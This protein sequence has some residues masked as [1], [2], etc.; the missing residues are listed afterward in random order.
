MRQIVAGR[1]WRGAAW[2]TGLLLAVSPAASEAQTAAKTPAKP[3][4]STTTR[5]ASAAPPWHAWAAHRC[6]ATT[7][8]TGPVGQA[9]SRSDLIRIVAEWAVD[10][11]RDV[12][13]VRNAGGPD[14]ALLTP[15]PAEPAGLFDP[16]RTISPGAAALAPFLARTA[17]G[18]AAGA[19]PGS[20][21]DEAARL[22][23]RAAALGGDAAGATAAIA[24]MPSGYGRARAVAAAAEDLATAGGAAAAERLLAQ[25]SAEAV[26]DGGRSL[27]VAIVGARV[28]AREFDAALAFI[29][30][31]P[32]AAARRVALFEIAL[33]Q[34]LAGQADA[35]RRTALQLRDMLP[36]SGPRRDGSEAEALAPD[37]GRLVIL[38][39]ALGET[40]EARAANDAAARLVDDGAIVDAIM[41]AGIAATARAL[42][43]GNRELAGRM[44]GIVVAVLRDAADGD[45]G[46]LD[47]GGVGSPTV[48]HFLEAVAMLRGPAALEAY[49]DAPGLSGSM[50]SWA[51]VVAVRLW[52]ERGDIGAALRLIAAIPEPDNRPGAAAL[53]AAIRLEAGDP[54]GVWQVL[55]AQAEEPWRSR[56]LREVAHAQAR[57][58]R[59]A[60]VTTLLAALP[61]PLARDT[62]RA[63]VAEALRE[64][65]DWSA[66]VAVARAIETRSARRQALKA[67]VDV[68]RFEEASRP[69]AWRAALEE[70]AGLVDAGEDPFER[71]SIEIGL[72]D[73]RAR[74][75]DRSG[76]RRIL[77]SALPGVTGVEP[78]ARVELLLE[79]AT[80]LIDHLGDRSAAASL[81]DAARNAVGGDMD[82][83]M[84]PL[85]RILGLSVRAVPDR[86]PDADLQR[87]RAELE[88]E[89]RSRSTLYTIA[90]EVVPMLARAGFRPAASALA[91]R[92]TAIAPDGPEPSL[93][94]D[95]DE[96]FA[97]YR[98]LRH[99][100][101]ERLGALIAGEA[102][103]ASR[104]RDED[105]GQLVRM[106]GQLAGIDDA[107]PRLAA[108]CPV[109]PLDSPLA[110]VEQQAAARREACRARPEPTC[111]VEQVLPADATAEIGVARAHAL[112]Q[113]LARLVAEGRGAAAR[114]AIGILERAVEAA[115]A[116]EAGSNLRL[117]Q[118]DEI[119]LQTALLLATLDEP[120]RALSIAMTMQSGAGRARVLQAAAVAMHRASD[121]ETA[122][123][124]LWLARELGG[125]D[126]K[127][128]AGLAVALARI[129]DVR[130]A[131]RATLAVTSVGTYDP[132]LLVEPLIGVVEARL[133]AGETTGL[134]DGLD[135]LTDGLPRDRARA[136]IARAH[137]AIGRDA[138][139]ETILSE[140]RTPGT[141]SDAWVVVA[142]AQLAAGRLAAAA[143]SARSSGVAALQARVAAWQ[144]IEPAIGQA[145]ALAKLG[146]LPDPALRAAALA[147]LCA[148]LVREARSERLAAVAPQAAA[149][150]RGLS[151]GA[152]GAAALAALADALAGSAQGS[153]ARTLFGEALAA[154]ARLPAG[155]GVERWTSR[156]APLAALLGAAHAL[157][158]RP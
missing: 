157:G 67:L 73:A 119:R 83:P 96:S 49:L 87:I 78:S 156:A 16:P 22:L 91:A 90:Q 1:G 158:A 71:L 112:G 30:T 70:A 109:P 74:A 20:L 84:R 118:R 54:K 2:L 146:R 106:L 135:M 28:A 44:I 150:A 126:E 153:L 143:R 89:D 17:A 29:R 45:L 104:R 94:D 152:A 57:L 136:G 3:P 40:A 121:G 124:M 138:E 102:T 82:E 35:A 18:L 46:R 12:L 133:R 144:L 72:A 21:S 147:A 26:R 37:Y 27:V 15:H 23:A 56:S 50:R 81:L 48:R 155:D 122:A 103:R 79:A 34:R 105:P 55:D 32:D 149:A 11:G 64:R 111:V 86:V 92:L 4:P 10:A 42:R 36:R 95:S 14:G 33:A 60:A 107:S 151:D 127:L 58:G 77:D 134:L 8:L 24:M 66:G 38:L 80:V 141:R 63:A 61:E 97:Y 128:A 115:D 7:L 41:R 117:G 6:V 51:R 142:Q 75:G 47:G 25:S 9:L 131:M 19:P 88:R 114:P 76:A 139:A 59:M 100:S 145:D 113:A 99:G 140:I 85:A 108:L 123:D 148:R 62:A 120:E 129:G 53:A 68:D 93:D 154:V 39:A 52:A 101:V 13:A 5:P 110:L 65:G 31:H 98:A 116:E 132:A 43:A 137:A 125:G 130:G 69:E